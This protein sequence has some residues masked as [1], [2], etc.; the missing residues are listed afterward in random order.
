M[1]FAEEREGIR[2]NVLGSLECWADGRRLALGGAKAERVL[3]FL[4]LSPNRSVTVARLVE[5]VWGTEPPSTAAHQIRKTVSTLRRT[6]PGGAALLRTDGAGYRAAVSARELDL[7]EFEEH[8]RAAADALSTDRP[9]DARRELRAALDLWRGPVLEGHDGEPIDLAANVL[10]E[11]RLAA[12]EQ[13]AR[14]R[15]EVGQIDGLTTYLRQYVDAHPLH[16][17]LRELLMT[18]LYRTG[19]HAEALE[20]FAQVRQLLAEE[21]GADPSPQ[22]A[23]LHEAILRRSPG[24]GGA[25]AHPPLLEPAVPEPV[26]VRCTLPYDLPDFTGRQDTVRRIRDAL[27]DDRRIIAID[28]MG[29]SGKTALAVHVANQLAERYPD[30]QLFLD[31]HGFT[32]GHPP[33]H[34]LDA[35]DQLLRSLGVP[36][37]R[38]PEGLVERRALWR[39]VTA[40]RRLLVVLDNIRESAQ[41]RP[42]LLGT[43]NSATIVT[44]RTRLVE[45]DGAEW[46]SVGSLSMEDSMELL[47]RV[48]GDDREDPADREHHDSTEARTLLAGM[49][50]GLPLALRIVSAR[51]RNRPHWTVRYLVDRMRSEARTLTELRVGERSVAA[52]L[53]L[54]YG[55]MNR[56]HRAA[57]RL[58][59]WHPGADFDVLSAAA[60]LGTDVQ[61]AEAI[62]EELLDVN[63]LEQH[64]VGRYT[65]HDLVRWFA[66]DLRG[67]TPDDRDEHGVQRLLD[68]Y[69]LTLERAC[70]LLFPGRTRHLVPL[71]NSTGSVPDF[72]SEADAL[73]WLDDEYPA[74]RDAAQLAYDVRLDLHAAYLPRGLAF[75]LNLRGWWGEFRDVG[76]LAVRAAR[77]LEDPLL[78]RISLTNLGMALWKLGDLRGSLTRLDEALALAERTSEVHGIAAALSRIGM[79]YSSLGQYTEALD[80]LDRALALHRRLDCRREEAETLANTASALNCLGRYAAAAEAAEH[81]VRLDRLLGERDHEIYAL[82]ELAVAHLGMGRPDKALLR[83]AGIEGESDGFR[84]PGTVGLMLAYRAETLQRLGRAREAETCALRA[85]TLMELS[86]AIRRAEIE[87]V[88]G[89]VHGRRH[90]YAAALTLHRAAHRRSAAMN[91]RVEMARAQAGVAAAAA[92]LGDPE[93]AVAARAAAEE[94]FTDIGVPEECRR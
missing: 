36:S 33:L 4:L 1:E 7:K 52:S 37:D 66:R 8:L 47:G 14:L 17:S 76:L 64:T 42:L 40:S 35:L 6:L 87:N 49:C 15:I 61:E 59:G 54:S 93:T 25:P 85:L 24:L 30:G 70:D 62:L 19:R 55:A 77:R 88:L 44:S 20:E 23:K 80:R 71:P 86:G 92:A 11:M 34:P 75:Y 45:I 26:I 73:R 48:L 22:L 74:L 12:V 89:R 91:L 31:L 72:D 2:L 46:Y 16:E 60:L 58:L 82:T 5:V 57:F 41:V 69:L 50:A 13:Y 94:L 3:G 21:L 68:H 90:D 63:L 56:T 67:N 53:Q 83:L 51:L 27:A 28:G 18:V 43:G 81:A 78:L 10:A 38:I 84:Q 65:L 9:T 79:C 29:G 39:S 32:P